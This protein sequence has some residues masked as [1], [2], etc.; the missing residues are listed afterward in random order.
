MSMTLQVFA[1]RNTHRDEVLRVLP[2]LRSADAHEENGWVWFLVSAWEAPADRL[3]ESLGAFTGPVLLATLH[4][5]E[6]WTLRIQG[7]GRMPFAICL[8]FGK[9][10][11]DDTE[12]P[13]ENSI[14]REPQPPETP[15]EV[16]IP[17]PKDYFAPAWGTRP[18][19]GLPGIEDFAATPARLGMPIPA[20][21]IDTLKREKPGDAIDSLIEWI[22][23]EII[24]ALEEFGIPHDTD[25]VDAA[26]LGDSVTDGELN[27]PEGNLPRF[28]IAIGITQSWSA[29][30][31]E[32]ASDEGGPLDE[33]GEAQALREDLNHILRH[34]AKRAPQALRDGT[35]TLAFEDLDILVRVAWFCSHMVGVAIG[36]ELPPGVML[37]QFPYALDWTP[38]GRGA[39]TPIYPGDFLEYQEDRNAITKVLAALPEDTQITVWFGDD[40][41][42]VARQ[43]YTG[44]IV[45]NQWRIEAS[46]PDLDAA[47]LQSALDFARI[48]QRGEPLRVKDLAEFKEA[49]NISLMTGNVEDALPRLNGLTVAG[50]EESRIE[51]AVALFRIRF[52]AQWD[53]EDIQKDEMREAIGYFEELDELFGKMAVPFKPQVL[54]EGNG[55]R[56]HEPDLS[57][58][59]FD[60]NRDRALQAMERCSAL[61]RAAGF[62]PCGAL[63]CNTHPFEMIRL[64]LRPERDALLMEVIGQLGAISRDMYTEFDDGLMLL[65]TSSA[66]K[67]SLPHRGVL[68]R[69]VDD[70]SVEKLREEHQEGIRRLSPAHGAPKPFPSASLPD[71]ARALESLLFRTEGEGQQPQEGPKATAPRIP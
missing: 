57:R 61:V 17:Q 30:L 23:D 49:C 33:L 47:V 36:F 35:V 16:A 55:R 59:D 68:V 50:D 7:E 8:E 37:E 27:T 43:C 66:R 54:L 69:P 12:E 34:S 32:A 44:P 60:G 31:Q 48:I 63:Y 38:K 64:Y 15:L 28:L 1:A 29:W 25:E 6:C 39:R 13:E 9:L 53:T 45:N 11:L 5:Y 4:D 51:L 14:I 62:E 2:E 18:P 56:F 20:E 21:V 46:T 10:L 26:L 19:D 52:H 67:Q 71:L 3:V 40:T 65:T 42:A 22:A 58:M 24:D 41:Y 70:P